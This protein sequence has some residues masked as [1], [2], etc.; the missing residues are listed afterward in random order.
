MIITEW[1]EEDRPRE[2]MMANGPAT[3]SNAELLAILIRT[4]QQGRTAVDLGRDI[5]HQADDSL[6]RLQ[7]MLLAGGDDERR[8]ALK[9]VGMAKA[10]SIQ[11]AFEIGRRIEEEKQRNR[12]AHT[13]IRSAEDLFL[14]FNHQLS[15]LDHEELWAV[16]CSKNGKMLCK[17]RISEGGVDYS[18]ADMRKILRP[19]IEHMASVCFLCHNH[20]HS[21]TRPS[22]PDIQL[23]LSAK[24]ALALL[25]VRL[26]DHIIIADGRYESLADKM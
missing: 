17:R 20:P 26:L 14:L 7:H 11:A 4:G 25:D 8:A 16:Y 13:F 18:G 22:Q 5:M 1:A 2:K 15:D 6:E 21:N 10:C 24:E 3:L 12:E 9:G 19:A 23:T